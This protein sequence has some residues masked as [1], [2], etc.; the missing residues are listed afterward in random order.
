M[1]S[2][3]QLY[4]L[5]K[6]RFIIKDATNLDISYAYED[7]VFSEHGL[8]LLQF[9]N[10]EGTLFDCWFNHEIDEPDEI[11]LF[12]SL[13]KT[14]T[15]NTATITYKGHFKLHQTVGTEQIHIEFFHRN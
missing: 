12:D 8:F 6:A 10:P 13:V 15:L 4:S 14:G 3:I 9:R 7:L 1:S 5:E 2:T 11:R